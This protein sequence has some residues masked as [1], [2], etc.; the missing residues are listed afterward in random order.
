VQI[1]WA[2]RSRRVK[3]QLEG[4]GKGERGTSAVFDKAPSLSLRKPPPNS[5][6][7][8]HMKA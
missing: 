5:D 4:L 1:V 7:G 8:Q 3:A 6:R 2:V